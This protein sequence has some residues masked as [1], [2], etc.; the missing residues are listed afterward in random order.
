[1]VDA[2]V[3]GKTGINT[4]RGKNLVG[5]FHPPAGVLCD[6]DTLATLPPHDYRGR[7]RRGGQVRL[8]RRP[9]D[10]RPDR[11]RP[12]RG[13]AVAGNAGRARAGRA[14][15]AGQGRGGRRGP[16]RAGPARDPQL[17]PHPRPR[18][19]AGR[20]LPLAARRGGV[21]RAGLRRRARPP[22]R[23]PRRRHRRPAPRRARRRS[24]CRPPTAPTPSPSCSRRCGSTRRRAAT[25][26][27]S[28][29]WTGWP[30]PAT[31]D[32]PDPAVLAAAYAEVGRHDDA[33]ACWCSTGRTSA[34]SAPASRTSTARTTYAELEAL[35]VRGGAELGLDVEVRQTDHEGEL[36]ELAARGRRRRH[37][38]RAQRGRA[39][40]H[41]GRARRRLRDAHRAAGRGA[42]Q[43]R[44]QARAVPAP[45]LRVARM[46]PA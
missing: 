36:L 6:L 22:A 40:A 38:G 33:R 19:R 34:G 15:G 26:C 32:D 21:G 11:G 7:A 3:G 1:M 27:G 43:Q 14:L 30:D 29:C 12:G 31:V 24:G 13:G 42:H 16:H 35:C 44:A 46:R 23:P 39:H 28:S 4:D 10:P 2:A 37:P 8:H 45:Q 5:A 9:G 18:D 41:L 20:A 25:G 17:R